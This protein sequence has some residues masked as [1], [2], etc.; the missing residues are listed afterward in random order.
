MT[1][2][3]PQPKKSNTPDF[4]AAG[5]FVKVTDDPTTVN[6]VAPV[7]KEKRKP[8][9]PREKKFLEIKSKHPDMPDYKAAQLVTGAKD[10]NVAST[11]AARLLQ[12]VTLREALEE[13]LVSQGFTV[14]DSAKAL[15]DALQAN[16]STAGVE[17]EK[18]EDGTT[19]TKPT[20]VETD[21]PDHGIRI[22]AARTILSFL[23]DKSDPGN[24]GGQTIN[25]I[26]N[27]LFVKKGDA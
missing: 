16:K 14:E 17:Y 8:L 23:T 24:G 27:N 15:V 25:F 18:F 7:K 12:N 19:T 26:G 4:S 11:Q 20:L 6:E 13:A 22:N 5:G 21:V 1:T 9:K 2:P 3:T 10:M